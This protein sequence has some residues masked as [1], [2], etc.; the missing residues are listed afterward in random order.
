VFS[1]SSLN[2]SDVKIGRVSDPEGK[3]YVVFS[4]K[5][6]VPPGK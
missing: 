3:A 2:R 6:F 1:F 5:P 4:R